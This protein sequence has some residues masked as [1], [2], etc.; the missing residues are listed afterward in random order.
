MAWEVALLQEAPPRWL[1]PLGR[2]AAAS[3][4]S[5]LTSRNF[6]ACA[7]AALAGL[8]PDL[9]ASGE[10]GSNQ[11]L[12]RDPARIVHVRRLTLTRR[13]ER[14]RM[15]FAVVRAPGGQL[16]AVANLHAT[17]GD[18]EG[19]A[20]DV[21][22]AAGRATEW[23]E[24]LPLVFGGDLNL[25]P[26]KDPDVFAELEHRYGLSAPADRDAIDHLLARGAR[27]VEPAARLPDAVRE[28]ADPA[29]RV[30]LSDHSPVAAAFGVR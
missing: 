20:R 29:G 8:N 10:G 13:P 2:A 11:I 7:R 6:G 26:A 1:E 14:R 21:R 17:A 24:G 22:L 3:G 5:A 15:L 4:A 19:A 27:V 12:V 9:M 30:L 18:R 28:A 25:R 16:L 23:A